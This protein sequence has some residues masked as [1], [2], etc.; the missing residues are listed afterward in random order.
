MLRNA[1]AGSGVLPDD[2]GPRSAQ[3]HR[4]DLHRAHITPRAPRHTASPPDSVATLF[5]DIPDGMTIAEYRRCAPRARRRAGAGAAPH[6]SPG[7]GRDSAA[8]LPLRLGH[9]QVREPDDGDQRRARAAPPTP[10]RTG[11]PGG[12]SDSR[13]QA[14]FTVSNA[15]QSTASTLTTVPGARAERARRA[16]TYRARARRAR[17][18]RPSGRPRRSPPCRTRSGCPPRSSRGRAAGRGTRRPPWSRSRRSASCARSTLR[19]KRDAG[20]HPVARDR[21]DRARRQRL[22]GHPAG[23]ERRPGPRPRT[24]WTTTIRT[25]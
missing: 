23:Q 20:Q 8:D 14:M 12:A 16:S 24:A 2:P 11:A 17:P 9:D 6:R 4:H 18:A 7:V 15:S 1:G 3:D 10:G 22:G 25:S 19:R 13:G 21:V 5:S